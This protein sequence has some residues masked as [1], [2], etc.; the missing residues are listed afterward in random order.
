MYVM[1]RKMTFSS[2]I[3]IDLERMMMI[4]RVALQ[5]RPEADQWVKTYTLTSSLLGKEWDKHLVSGKE[6][7]T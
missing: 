1:N 6:K 5:G 7:V 2:N 3:Q 4:S